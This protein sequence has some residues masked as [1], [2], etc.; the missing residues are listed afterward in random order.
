MSVSWNPWH[1][2]H[3]F[4][5]GCAHCYV[6]RMDEQHQ[7]DSSIVHKTASFDLPLRKDRF[8]NDKILPGETVMTCFTSDFLIEDADEWRTEAWKIM[9]LRSDLQ[10]FFVTKRIARLM[11]C[12]PPDWGD[13]YPNVEI[14][15]TMENQSCAEERLPIFLQV[16]IARK[17]IICEPLLGPIDL[18]PYLGDWVHEVIAGGESG[19]EA[20]LCDYEWVLSLRRQC[21]QVKTAFHFKQTGARFCKDGRIYQI[22]RRL[23]QEQARKAGIDYRPVGKEQL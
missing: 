15:C 20:R 18:S 8:G 10:F 13:G 5:A 23:Q 14:C 1:G 22:P 11:Q 12:L 4:S 6:Y 3:K 2:C 9:R 7:K 17:S 21:I 19:P 16:P